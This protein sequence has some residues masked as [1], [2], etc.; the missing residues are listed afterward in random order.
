MVKRV[1]IVGGGYA[2]TALSK[3][4]DKVAD[5][6]L[7]GSLAT[8]RGQNDRG[9]PNGHSE[10]ATQGWTSA[11]LWVLAAASVMSHIAIIVFHLPQ[12]VGGAMIASSL[13]LFG[14]LHARPTIAGGGIWSFLAAVLGWG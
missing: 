13:P 10:Q 4:L 11:L 6:Q 3:A 7:C 5:V 9:S 8:L 2:G 12:A 14:L 1:I